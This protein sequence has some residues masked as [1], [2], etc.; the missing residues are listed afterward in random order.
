MQLPQVLRK[1]VDLGA[2]VYRKAEGSTL[3]CR[4]VTLRYVE[5]IKILLESPTTQMGLLSSRGG[6]ALTLARRLGYK[7]V[8]RLLISYLEI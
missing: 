5:G 2:N 7:E 1:L 3:L 6:H 8:E 4:A